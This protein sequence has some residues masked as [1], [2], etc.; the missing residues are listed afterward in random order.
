MVGVIISQQFA[1]LGMTINELSAL[2][3]VAKEKK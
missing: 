3:E 1:F 2:I